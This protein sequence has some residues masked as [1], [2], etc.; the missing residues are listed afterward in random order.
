MLPQSDQLEPVAAGRWRVVRQESLQVAGGCLRIPR[1]RGNVC[2]TLH[3][4]TCGKPLDRGVGAFA[5]IQPQQSAS[6]WPFILS[7]KLR[8]RRFVRHQHADLGCMAHHQVEPDQRADTAAEYRRRTALQREQHS[9]HVL[10][11]R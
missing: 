6:P 2:V 1:P 8:K 11:V 9:G 10:A 4:E 5:P 7:E 3:A